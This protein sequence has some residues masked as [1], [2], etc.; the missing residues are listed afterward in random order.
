MMADLHALLAAEFGAAYEDLR[1]SLPSNPGGRHGPFTT[2]PLSIVK[3]I[4]IHHTA[5]PK[6]VGWQVI[7]AEHIR[8]TASGGRLEA[9]GIGYHVGIRNGRVSYLGDVT[10]T[11]A[12][13]GGQNHLVIGVCVAGDYTRE[14]LA[15]VDRDA[16]AR[17]V[18]VMDDF[19]GRRLTLAGHGA[20]ALPGQ[21]TACPGPPLTAL[22]PSLRTF[23][24]APAPVWELGADGPAGADAALAA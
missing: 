22:L 24:P 14:P 11:R 9:A 1:T 13:V 3:Y 17:V 2:R 15:D 20:L 12:N 6:T 23:A 16:L 19:M 18:K 8:P 4:A 7:A 21:A 10:T 5:G